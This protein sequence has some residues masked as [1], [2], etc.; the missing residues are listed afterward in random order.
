MGK[1]GRDQEKN[2][3]SKEPLSLHLQPLNAEEFIW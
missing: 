1:E 3:K 2:W